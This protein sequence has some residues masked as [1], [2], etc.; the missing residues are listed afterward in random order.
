MNADLFVSAAQDIDNELRRVLNENQSLDTHALYGML[1]YFFGYTDESLRPLTLSSGK[2]FRAALTLIIADGYGARAEALQAALAIEL[3]H[4]FTLIHDDVEDHDEIR[5]NR[6]TVWKLWGVNHAINSGDLL[7]LLAARETALTEPNQARVLFDAY[8]KVIEGQYLDFE[9]SNAPCHT[10]DRKDYMK[11]IAS[12]TGALIGAAA[13]VAGLAANQS[14]SECLQLRSYGDSLGTLFQLCD[15]YSSIWNTTNATG[16]DFHSDIREHKRTL[17]FF[18]AYAN[19]SPTNRTRLGYLFSLDRALKEFEAAE[20][21]KI[22]DEPLY[23]KEIRDLIVHYTD[24]ALKAIEGL[25][26]L[27]TH[28]HSLVGIASSLAQDIS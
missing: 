21:Y 23:Q 15:D 19:S 12:K 24:K 8:A 10:I 28:K 17:P 14:V 2:R 5:R 3:F 1:R 20:A 11:M 7:G 26:L 4:N 27:A 6:P 13:Q 22:I 25:S 16:K 18:I 9:L